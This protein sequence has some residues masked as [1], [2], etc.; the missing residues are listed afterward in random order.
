LV[1]RF[2]GTTWDKVIDIAGRATSPVNCT[3]MEITG[4]VACFAK[5]T[6]TAYWGIRFNGGSWTSGQ[7]GGWGTLGGLVSP[8]GSCAA[9]GTGE[10]I[11]GVVGVTDSALWVNQ[12]A[13]AGWLGFVRV[14]QTALGTPG[15]TSLGAGKALCAIV[16]V[17]GKA[18]STVGP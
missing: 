6:D 11:C 5:G 18:W 2:N 16:S 15:C 12:F 14:G 1:D 4:E 7:W 13:G 8:G 9:Y 3:P 17:N 10:I